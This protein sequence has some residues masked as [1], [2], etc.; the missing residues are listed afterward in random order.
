MRNVLWLLGFSLFT[1]YSV[2]VNQLHSLLNREMYKYEQSEAHL[3]RSVVRIFNKHTGRYGVGVFI[4]P[5]R[6]ATN[7]HVVCCFGSPINE[8]LF[9]KKEGKSIGVD[10]IVGIDPYSDL[11]VMEVSGFSSEDFIPLSEENDLQVKDEIRTFGYIADYPDV[12]RFKGKKVETGSHFYKGAL[13]FYELPGMSGAPVLKKGDNTLKGIVFTSSVNIA[14]I[15]PVRKLKDLMNKEEICSDWKLCQSSAMNALLARIEKSDEHAE[16]I[17]GLLLKIGLGPYLK[18]YVDQDKVD[19]S[20]DM[21]FLWYLAAEKNHKEAKLNM[22]MMMTSLKNKKDIHKGIQYIQEAAEAGD[23]SANYV[24]SVMFR[25]FLN[26]IEENAFDIETALDIWKVLG[27]KVSLSMEDTLDRW[28]A[29]DIRSALSKQER[30]LIIAA[31][32]GHVFA[33]VDLGKFYYKK[34]KESN[35]DE[36]RKFYKEEALSWCRKAAR[37]HGHLEAARRMLRILSK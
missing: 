22:G 13:S 2:A 6:V 15:V 21:W 18:D 14:S 11:A 25:H 31:S 4:N 34:Y 24:M 19:V 3:A 29:L 33:E 20:S 1:N 32:Q 37:D 9:I 26:K 36:E 5:T 7:F 8:T 10:K 23:I 30:Y 16:Y 12:L 27:I 35:T 28:D 17:L